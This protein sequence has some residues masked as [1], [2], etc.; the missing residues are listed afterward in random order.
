MLHAY[1]RSAYSG[2]KLS[3]G[4]RRWEMRECTPHQ[5]KRCALAGV[6]W[7][8]LAE[9]A[10]LAG[11]ESELVRWQVSLLESGVERKRSLLPLGLTDMEGGVVLDEV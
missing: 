8:A 9:E 1:V 6:E 11:L 10:E 2:Q 3:L 5:R 4:G 7:R